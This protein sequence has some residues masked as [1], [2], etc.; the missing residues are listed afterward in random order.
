MD[1]LEKGKLIRLVQRRIHLEEEVPLIYAGILTNEIL[2]HADERVLEGV[3]KWLDNTLTED[4]EVEGI[5]LQAI[6]EGTKASLIGALC[7][8]DVYIKNPESLRAL[9]WSQKED[10][11]R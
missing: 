2:N 7:M 9:I 10:E 3:Q 5:S 4:F 8:L 6:R 1:T 11:I